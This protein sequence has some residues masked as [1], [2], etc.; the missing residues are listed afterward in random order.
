M[1]EKVVQMQAVSPL[2][3]RRRLGHEL[4]Q[5]REAAGLIADQLSRQVGQS[6]SKLSRVETAERVP[7]VADVGALLTALG[8]DG[9]YS[10]ALVT[11]GFQVRPGVEQPFDPRIVVA[12]LRS[13]GGTV[14]L[15]GVYGPTNG[16][17]AHSSSNR[18]V[19]QRRLLAYLANH[20]SPRLCV[21]GDLNVV[22]PDH[23]PRLASFEAHDYAFYT[24]LLDLGLVD[25]YGAV[26]PTGVEHSWHSERYGSQRLDHLLIAT[27]L[28]ADLR[29]FRYD[30]E[31]RTR[32]LSDHAAAIAVL[33]LT[34]PSTGA[35]R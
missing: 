12:D 10:T 4:R 27:G 7:N 29:E 3:R 20:R 5:L 31:P 2:I 13:A 34:P 28:A 18:S 33:T 6:R 16:M 32:E 11:K 14:R 22:E 1:L 24:G 26:H 8:V 9:Q 19:F 23:E 25:A 30:H 35:A 21:A 15:A 17:T